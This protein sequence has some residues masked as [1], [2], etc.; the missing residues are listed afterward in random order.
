[1]KLII[2]V[3]SFIS[4][5]TI[6]LA[7]AGKLLF[8][9]PFPSKSHHILGEELAKALLKRGHHVTMITSFHVNEKLSNYT[10]ILLETASKFKQG[11]QNV[12]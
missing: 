6:F 4:F 10:E 3:V 1:M 8:V 2:V 9:V 12:S 7:Q 5:K 11:K